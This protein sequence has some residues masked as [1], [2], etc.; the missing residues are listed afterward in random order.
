[1][2]RLMDILLASL[3]YLAESSGDSA[4]DS[5]ASLNNFLM[6]SRAMESVSLLF[7]RL[8]LIVGP[9]RYAMQVYKR[10]SRFSVEK[11]NLP[12]LDSEFILAK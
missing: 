12:S 6:R 10:L 7:L 4:T 9:H 8:L 11:E 2:R 1:M 3:T 5:P